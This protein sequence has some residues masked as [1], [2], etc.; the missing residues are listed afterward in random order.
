M[1]MRSKRIG[2]CLLLVALL[3]VSAVCIVACGPAGNTGSATASG[4]EASQ[5]AAPEGGIPR[6]DVVGIWHIIESGGS[7]AKAFED[8]GMF[9]AFQFADDG[10]FTNSIIILD[11]SLDRVGTYEIRDGKIYVNLPEMEK[12]E[13]KDDNAQ[14]KSLS[15]KAIENAELTLDNGILT[16]NQ[17]SDD[18]SSLKA[19]KITEKEYKKLKKKA[20]AMGPKAVKVGKEVKGDFYTFTVD[21]LEFVDEVYP[22]DTSGYY[23]YYQHQDGKS[24]LTAM[25]TYTNTGNEYAMPCYATEAAFSIG[26]N[27]YEASIEIDGGSNFS[28]SYEVAA[29]DTAKIVI[30]TAV[31]DKV[32]DSGDVKLVWSIPK[33]V[34][35]MQTYHSYSKSN[36][37]YIVTM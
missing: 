29:Q 12:I 26:D 11:K 10:T 4:S 34:G 37:E 27:K 36:D 3:L 17:F 25:V 21:S 8:A 30:C 35:M 15:A 14:L 19:E 7:D 13:S 33:D 31:P 22:S 9:F 23:R 16:T 28:A 1:A 20:A 5:K 24:Y 32:K 2:T 6:E 18:G